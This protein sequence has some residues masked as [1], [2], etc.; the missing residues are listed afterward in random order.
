MYSIDFYEIRNTGGESRFEEVAIEGGVCVTLSLRGWKVFSS[1]LFSRQVC[2]TRYI[3]AG[4][5][6][7]ASKVKRTTFLKRGG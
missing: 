7:T 6:D 1:K 2:M 4:V 5:I 3:K